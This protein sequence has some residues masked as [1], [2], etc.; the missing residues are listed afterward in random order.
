MQVTR[1]D[2]QFVAEGSL[3]RLA[4]RLGALRT[5]VERLRASEYFTVGASRRFRAVQRR[6]TR[7]ASRVGF[8]IVAG[9]AA[10]DGLV[11]FDPHLSESLNLLVLNGGVAILA[12]AGWKALPGPL[13]RYP[14]P[15]AVVITLAM[16]GATAVTGIVLPGLAVE[17][18]GYLLVFPGLIALILPWQTRTHVRWL[19]A[20][21]AIALGFLAFETGDRLSTD[22]RGD[23]M[24][25]AL[26]ALV[27]SLAGHV[28]LQRAQIRNFSQLQKIQ[29]LRR[30]A[31]ADMHELAR[32]YHA[33]E[34]T[35]RTDPL[36]G[37]ANRIRLREDLLAVR[38]RM[39][40]RGATQGLMAIDLDRFKLIN[41][42][43]GHLA[44]DDV[45]RKSVAALRRTLRAEDGL[46]RF[47]GEEFVVLLTDPDAASL[48]GTAERLRQA[49]ADLGIAHPENVPYGVVTI[50]L[51][52]VLLT[53]DDLGQTDDEWFARA[54]VAL[55]LAKELGR[56]RFERASRQARESRS[57]PA[58]VPEVAAS[59]VTVAEVTTVADVPSVRIEI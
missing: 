7:T 20:Y 39:S 5:L 29:S 4:G 42:G 30:R 34:T 14:E 38:S 41:D 48:A 23:L 45:L 8:L 57:D 12:L 56:N 26:I 36:T 43:F 32:V 25:V 52:V 54:D 6:R 17:S 55:Y 47:G 37:A 24:V 35:A 19:V 46:Y 51:G 2:T 16:A 40:R 28:L 44:G 9:A 21:A 50:S 22:E 33:L 49:V 31:D 11:V 53:A 27:A 58:E 1:R 3:N 18:V 13:R 15:A 10:F 59:E